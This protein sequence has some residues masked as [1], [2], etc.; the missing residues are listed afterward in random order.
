MGSLD[1]SRGKLDES[2]H[3]S[4]PEASQLRVALNVS[5]GFKVLTPGSRLLI[6]LAGRKRP[7]GQHV[8]FTPPLSSIMPS[9]ILH[10]PLSTTSLGRIFR[11]R[12]TNPPTWPITLTSHDTQHQ[13]QASVGT[14]RAR[15]E[16]RRAGPLATTPRHARR[17]AD[18]RTSKAGML[19]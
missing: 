9:A 15:G 1:N 12:S 6:H 3:S 8:T 10:L 7:G 5:S 2:G 14:T 11:Q 13:H 17:T 4:V 19:H 18:N 16:S